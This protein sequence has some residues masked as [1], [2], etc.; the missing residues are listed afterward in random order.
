MP[1]VGLEMP[2]SYLFYVFRRD[3]E[4]CIY[5]YRRMRTKQPASIF[6]RRLREARERMGIAQD[7]LGVAI[8]LDEGSASARISRYE[9]GIHEP[10]FETAEQLAKVLK[11]PAAYFYCSDD[12]LANLVLLWGSLPRTEKRRAV[13]VLAA[14]SDMQ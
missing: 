6:G 5:E 2:S 4:R 14:N 1:P 13:A 10:P 11:I 9:T 3:A 8:G 12:D 7:R